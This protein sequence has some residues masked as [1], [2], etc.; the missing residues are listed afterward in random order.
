MTNEYNVIG[1]HKEN[2]EHL[3]VV[4]DD[5][6]HYDYSLTSERVEP[7]QVDDRW[8]VDEPNKGGEDVLMD[9]PGDDLS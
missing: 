2:E 5:G 4:G 8:N 6:Q 9:M 3:L 1:E 7:V